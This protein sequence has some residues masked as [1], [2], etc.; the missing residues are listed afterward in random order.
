MAIS[1]IFFLL[2]IAFSLW[3][4]Q[5]CQWNVSIGLL[6]VLV[7]TFIVVVALL[8]TRPFVFSGKDANNIILYGTYLLSSGALFSIPI[9][10]FKEQIFAGKMPAIVKKI[11]IYYLTYSIIL[12]I[13]ITI[14]ALKLKS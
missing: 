12:L 7:L 13:L 6:I 2:L 14:E 4:L 10:T 8:I 11:L 9:D 1:I 3:V 5:V